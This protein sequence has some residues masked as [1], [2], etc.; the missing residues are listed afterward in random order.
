MILNWLSPTK[1]WQSHKENSE[2]SKAIRAYGLIEHYYQVKNWEKLEQAGN[3]FLD[4]PR[5]LC[6]LSDD[7]KPDLFIM[8][9]CAASR[10]GMRVNVANRSGE[11][12]WECLREGGEMYPTLA[13]YRKSCMSTLWWELLAYVC[14][15]AIPLLMLLYA[16][17]HLLSFPDWGWLLPLVYTALYTW[18]MWKPLN[19]SAVRLYSHLRD[20]WFNPFQDIR[21]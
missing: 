14:L 11:R 3:E 16:A 10:E 12:A 13:Y 9:V 6:W 17:M 2:R 20:P 19:E 1:S 8:L 15:L 7:T 21:Q 18:K 4:D 5:K